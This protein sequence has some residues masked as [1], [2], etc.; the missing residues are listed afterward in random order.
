MQSWLSQVWA[1]LQRRHVVRVVFGYVVIA[2]AIGGVASDFLPGLGAPAW[3]LATVLTLLVLGVPITAVVAW[4]YELTPEGIRA[5][6]PL[7][8]PGAPDPSVAV[9]AFSNMSSG[10]EQDYFADGLSEE[11]INAL[12]QVAGLR[13]VGRTSAFALKGSTEDLRTIGEKLN[14]GAVLEGSVRRSETRLRI[15]AQL[16]DTKT[17][18]HLFSESYDRPPGDAIEVQDEIAHAVTQELCE[19]LPGPSQDVRTLPRP[20]SQDPVAYEAYLRGMFFFWQY[21]IEGSRRALTCFKEALEHDPSYA[22]AHAGA[23]LCY[24]WLAGFGH[25]EADSTPAKARASA[26]HALDLEPDL[27]EGLVSLAEALYYLDWEVEGAKRALLK[28]MRLSPSNVH[29]HGIVR[30]LLTATG[31]VCRGSSRVREG[32]RVGP[33][34]GP[35]AQR[36][37][38]PVRCCRTT[39][40]RGGSDRADSCPGQ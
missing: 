23:S 13:V 30:Q 35:H 36:A 12:A 27:P 15:T 1:E 3:A 6:V 5:T 9:M 11:I 34:F 33:S 21:S 26:E 28:A 38:Q 29:A 25:E 39:G 16:V 19:T 2:A 7:K 37:C 20:Q 8:A 40:R 10:P 24:T 4:V 18:Y 17:G 31:R 22:L 32:H 14:V